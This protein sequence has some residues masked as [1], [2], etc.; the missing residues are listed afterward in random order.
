[1]Q[2]VPRIG[3]KTALCSCYESVRYYGYGPNE[4]YI[5]RR[6][7]SI[8]DVYDDTVTN[9][10]VSYVMPQENGSHYGSEWLE[11]TNGKTTVRVEGDFSFSALPHSVE[12]YTNYKHNWELPEREYTHLCIDYFMSGIGSNSCGPSLADEWKTPKKGNGK[13]TIIIK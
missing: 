4:S 5:D 8:K 13:F 9:L 10:E 7:S 12:E 2:F 3:F 6:L 11:L 1:M